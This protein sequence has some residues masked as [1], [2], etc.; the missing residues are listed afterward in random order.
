[1]LSVHFLRGLVAP[2]GQSTTGTFH[3]SARAKATEHTSLVVFGRL[4]RRRHSVVG[5]SENCLTCGADTI[6]SRWGSQAER[7]RAGVAEDVTTTI[8]QHT[9]MQN[10]CDDIGTCRW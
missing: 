6:G 7:V 2:E 5:L 4:Q 9:G 10:I 3:D 1:M 8:D